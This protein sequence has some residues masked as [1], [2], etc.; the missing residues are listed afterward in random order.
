MAGRPRTAG[1]ARRG[2]DSGNTGGSADRETDVVNGSTPPAEDGS[3]GGHRSATVTLPF[4]TAQVRMP[5]LRLPSRDDVDAVAQGVQHK[6]PSA[7]ALLF[8]GGLTATAVLGAI[9]WPVAAAIGVGSALASRSRAD[10]QPTDR[11]D[12]NR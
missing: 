6:L 7:K 11:R 10:S 12:V 9:E 5:S 8:L 4:L 2:R 3:G 1:V